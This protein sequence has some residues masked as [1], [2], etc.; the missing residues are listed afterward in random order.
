MLGC[1]MWL[2]ENIKDLL[3]VSRSYFF[4]SYTN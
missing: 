1:I 2:N 4:A 3:P